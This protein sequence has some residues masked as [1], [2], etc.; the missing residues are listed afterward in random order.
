M[1]RSRT[2]FTLA[3]TIVATMTLTSCSQEAI[4]PS[5]FV[6]AE[7][8]RLYFANGDELSL[9]GVNLQPCLSW[10]YHSL[11]KLIGLPE[12]AETLKKA[13]DDALDEI[14]KMRCDVIRAHLVPSDF[15]DQ[16]GNLVETVYLDLLD[17]MVAEAAKRDIYVYLSF[18]NPHMSYDID[19]EDPSQHSPS[20]VPDTFL[21]DFERKELTIDP[22]FI[23]K[24]KTYV[25]QLLN[26]RNPYNQKTYKNTPEIALWEIANEPIYYSYKEIKETRNYDVFKKWAKD[27]GLEDNEESYFKFRHD[28]TLE[29]IN[30]MYDTVRATGTVQPIVWNCNWHRMIRGRRDVFDAIA[31]SKVEVV[32]FCNYPGQSILKRPYTKNPEDL[33]RH[34][35]ADFLRKSYTE[36]D[37]YDWALTPEFMKKAKV[38]YEF[39]TFYNYS[40]YLYPA[41]AEFFRAMGVQSATMWHYSMPAYAPYRNGSHHLSLTSTPPKAMAYAIAG[42]TFRNTPLY[43]DYDTESPTEKIGENVMYSYAKDAS[44]YSDADNYLHTGDVSS[45]QLPKPHQ[46][47]KR[48][49]GLGSSP[50]VEYTGTG[51]YSVEISE[52]KIDITIEANATHLKPLWGKDFLKEIV[53]Q[54]DYET[55]HPFE[56]KLDNWSASGSKVSRIEANGG[57]SVPLIGDKLK[58]EA[59]PG[60]YTISR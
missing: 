36:K 18:L 20:V 1:N 12:T 26:R 29:Y 46:S 3:L 27:A 11:F 23:E 22:V 16:D 25:T 31:K 35:F 10:E 6:Y 47:V 13:T 5:E 60:R 4:D 55:A 44:L 33:S 42:Q 14:E 54:L 28:R 37:W 59:L 41:Q 50:L 45:E 57:S 34:D 2:P 43:H 38:V 58:F 51:I 52:D 21:N 8:G 39:E 48:I 40:S 7:D 49:T 24:S 30:A 19:V 9:W 56:L 15:A 17:Y 32:S 53:T